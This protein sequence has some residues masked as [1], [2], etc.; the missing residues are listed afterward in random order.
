M[1][2]NK[3]LTECYY[4]TTNLFSFILKA[5]K[6]AGKDINNLTI[7]DLAPV[8]AFH[9]RGI[10]ATL[11]LASLVKIKSGDNILDIG[12]GIGGSARYLAYNYKCFVKG[13]DITK[14]YCKAAAELSKLLNLEDKTEF[15]HADAIDLPFENESFNIVWSEHV[16]MNIENKQKLYQ[17]IYRVLTP[18]GKLIFYDVFKG[19]GEGIFYPVPWADDSSTDFLTWQNDTK[20]LIESLKF[21]I[22]YWEDI[23]ELSKNWFAETVTK[24]RYRKPYSL[25]L[26][27]LMGENA[28]DKF[29]NM[30]RNLNE[31]KITVVQAL[32]EKKC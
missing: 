14:E 26:H 30:V 8:D 12:C 10:V 13:V 4:T 11:D 6:A 19:K 16:Q 17:E 21:K 15:Q 5:L 28:D 20:S 23:T 27:L 31:K 9:I 29:N 2:D 7:K 22:N 3:R 25:G 18:H 24:M 1:G 32:I